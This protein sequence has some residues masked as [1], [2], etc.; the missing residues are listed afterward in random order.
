MSTGY[1]GWQ[2][3]P[4]EIINYFVTVEERYD[5]LIMDWEF[6]SPHE[7]FQFYAPGKCYKCA[8]GDTLMYDP[9]KRQLFALKPNHL[10]GRYIYRTLHK[11]WYPNGEVAFSLTEIIGQPGNRQLQNY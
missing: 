11:V 4:K 5:Q 2:S 1:W 7:F 8:V 6:N 9:S 10:P 3:G